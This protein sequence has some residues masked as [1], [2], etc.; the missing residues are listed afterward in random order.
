[1]KKSLLVKNGK[2]FIF[3]F[4]EIL[5]SS[6]KL[7]RRW[8]TLFGAQ[9]S[10]AIISLETALLF[11]TVAL[12]V[13]MMMLPLLKRKILADEKTDAILGVHIIGADAGTMIAE[14]VLA[15]A[16]G[17]SAEDVARTCHAHPTMSEAVKEAALGAWQKPIHM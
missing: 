8:L 9:K 6:L 7:S 11:R 16:F 2:R 17:G 12:G 4:G 15:M 1:M 13:R 3:I 10:K 5:L 14:A